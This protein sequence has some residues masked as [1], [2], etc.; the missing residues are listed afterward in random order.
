M[1][2]CP[3]KS[4]KAAPSLTAARLPAVNVF[5]LRTALLCSLELVFW[6]ITEA[7]PYLA[8]LSVAV[9]CWTCRLSGFLAVSA[10]YVVFAKGNK[11]SDLCI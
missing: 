9:D 8:A 11:L 1:I 3:L 7:V 4:S 10:H 6:Y 2:L 5:T